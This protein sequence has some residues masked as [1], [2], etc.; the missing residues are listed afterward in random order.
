MVISDCRCYVEL[1]RCYTVARLDCVL[2]LCCVTRRR[3]IC[4]DYSVHKFL[5]FSCHS[6]PGLIDSVFT[7]ILPSSSAPSSLVKSWP[8]ASLLSLLTFNDS[9]RF[10]TGL[11]VLCSLTTSN[12]FK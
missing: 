5:V 3:Q 2:T 11:R 4:I 12:F 8:H 10:H 7:T 6:L 1:S 9:R